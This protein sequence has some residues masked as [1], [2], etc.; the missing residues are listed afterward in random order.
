MHFNVTFEWVFEQSFEADF[1]AM[2]QVT[3]SKL[4]GKYSDTTLNFDFEHVFECS[5]QWRAQ[6][7][8]G[9]ISIRLWMMR[10]NGVWKQ[11]FECYV[12]W[13]I[14]TWIQDTLQWDFESEFEAHLND[15][16]DSIQPMLASIQVSIKIVLEWA[17]R[18][19]IKNLIEL[20]TWTN[21]WD[22]LTSLIRCLFQ[23]DF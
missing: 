7:C 23:V 6:E 16:Y 10:L 14:Q 2:F 9:W 4:V 18:L 3:R 22:K 20:A 15:F 12:K 5:V 13:L 8:C 21:S 17:F 19:T 11:I 1:N